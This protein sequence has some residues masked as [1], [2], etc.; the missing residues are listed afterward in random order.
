MSALGQINKKEFIERELTQAIKLS[1]VDKEKR[2]LI[3]FDGAPYNH[4]IKT[5]NADNI[6]N[7]QILNADAAK[8]IY[9]SDGKNGAIIITSKNYYVF[10]VE[11]ELSIKFKR[12]RKLLRK[13]RY[14]IGYSVNN[15]LLEGNNYEVAKQIF[16]ISE[17]D[18]IK[19]YIKRIHKPNVD[20]LAVDIKTK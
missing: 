2:P 13:S 8:T 11:N 12:Y 7:I 1:D 5:F 19:L 15:T 4:T 9:A 10:Y 17:K 6:A 20:S 16:D 3:I 14:H 18:I